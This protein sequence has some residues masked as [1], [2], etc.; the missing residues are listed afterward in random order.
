MKRATSV[1]AFA[2][3]ALGFCP[4]ADAVP[5]EITAFGTITSASA[6]AP[7]YWPD[8]QGVF[9]LGD[10]ITATLRYD[11]EAWFGIVPVSGLVTGYY[12]ANGLI[13]TGTGW[14]HEA[15]S[16]FNVGV[17]DITFTGQSGDPRYYSGFPFFSYSATL[18]FSDPFLAIPPDS[19]DA[20][21]FRSGTLT[22]L[23]APTPYLDSSFTARIDRITAVVTPIPAS[24]WLFATAL[25][26]L[27]GLGRKR[28][29]AARPLS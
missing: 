22:S 23:Y 5:V 4:A 29:A 2:A 9:V 10:Q 1:A 24:G 12:P 19:I 7:D 13:T 21:A 6:N 28:A 25:A 15:W 11:S 18:S 3:A 26:G 14:S 8:Y 17:S 27:A 20:P 16:Y